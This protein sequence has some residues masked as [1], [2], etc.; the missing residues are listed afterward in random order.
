MLASANKFFDAVAS[1]INLVAT[2]VSVNKLSGAVAVEQLLYYCRTESSV[3]PHPYH[4]ISPYGSQ[5]YQL[6][7]GSN[8]RRSGGSTLIIT[9]PCT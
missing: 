3:Y 5:A 7:F 1:D 6:V 9:H 2:L 8:G 4:H